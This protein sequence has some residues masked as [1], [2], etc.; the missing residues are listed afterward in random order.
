M[1]GHACGFYQ[2]S[3]DVYSICQ[4]RAKALIERSGCSLARDLF[5]SALLLFA[6]FG[7]LVMEFGFLRVLTTLNWTQT[8]KKHYMSS[9]KHPVL[10]SSVQRV[11]WEREWAP[12]SCCHLCPA[13]RGARRSTPWLMDTLAGGRACWNTGRQTACSGNAFP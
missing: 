13:P 10:G 4:S 6:A 5:S 3:Q 7:E 9:S 12:F 8:R 1:Q 2:C 11:L